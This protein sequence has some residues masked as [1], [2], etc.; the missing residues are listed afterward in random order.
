MLKTSWKPKAFQTI[1]IFS[2]ILF[3][4][5]FD[6]TSR[7]HN[8]QV[9][10]NRI[11]TFNYLCLYSENEAVIQLN[12]IGID[13]ISIVS[14]KSG[15][16]DID[17]WGKIAGSS[18]PQN[19][20]IINTKNITLVKKTPDLLNVFL[21]MTFIIV[22]LSQSI[23]FLNY[24][25]N[26]S[27]VYVHLLM[28][29][30][31]LLLFFLN[32]KNL[33]FI[34]LVALITEFFIYSFSKKINKFQIIK[35][36]NSDIQNLLNKNTDKIL[37][38]VFLTVLIRRIYSFWQNLPYS[39]SNIDN[40]ITQITAKRSVELKISNFEAAYNHH[41]TIVNEF[42]KISYNLSKIFFDYDFFSLKGHYILLIFISIASGLLM[43]LSLQLLD[44]SKTLSIFIG[45]VL[46]IEQTTSTFKPLRND[47]RT[48]ESLFLIVLVFLFLKFNSTSKW[49]S[50]IGFFSFI[51]FYNLETS[52]FSIVFIAL[53]ILYK[54]KFSLFE[55]LPYVYGMLL[56]FS[57]V[58]T[59]LL[60]SGDLM[61]VVNYNYL[62]HLKM[63]RGQRESV[64]D[65]IGFLEFKEL[66][67]I[68]HFIFF[69]CIVFT[70]L[71][72]KIFSKDKRLDIYLLKAIFLGQF[73]SIVF[74]GPRF[75]A[76]GLS[77]RIPYFLITAYILNEFFKQIKVSKLKVLLLFSIS[78][79]F[80]T[81][82]V[83]GD[84]EIINNSYNSDSNLKINEERNNLIYKLNQTNKEGAPVFSW[85]PP[86][87]YFWLYFNG[88]QLPATRYWW[89]FD[90]KYTTINWY[91][92][93]G[94][95]DETQVINNIYSDLDFEETKVALKSKNSNKNEV[96]DK[97][98]ESRFNQFYC[99]DNYCLYL[100]K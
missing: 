28:S 39:H 85:I 50:L 38:A 61:R 4:L 75:A 9:I 20:L 96:F 64:F 81:S 37:F 92:W 43:F 68:F 42:N 27:R 93:Q 69:I 95:W 78:P 33:I 13:N 89:W 22:I 49:L 2:I 71:N 36:F 90:M 86:D 14:E 47:V 21:S 35:K 10:E 8:Q 98:L 46:I 55:F 12:E 32:L 100:S 56:S 72:S 41:T 76:Y 54:L 60:I 19:E 1:I 67:T 58:L 30:L 45:F 82:F 3:L 40:L 7:S 24:K 88:E 31:I 51:A 48:Y 16:N 53:L 91:N 57:V 52:L 65:A 73:I 11:P 79:F 94:I 66:T 62:F 15:I 6:I 59:H 17:C 84:I 18:K 77:L 99:S 5:I 87:D 29:S 23:F 44:V 34:L 80:M 63:E 97:V 70:L 83:Y 25:Y 26:K 74:T